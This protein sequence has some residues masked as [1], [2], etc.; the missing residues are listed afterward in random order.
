MTRIATDRSNTSK[1]DGYYYYYDYDLFPCCK[2]V[3]VLISILASYL[4]FS[5]LHHNSQLTKYKKLAQDLQ[6]LLGSSACCCVINKIDRM[7]KG[8]ACE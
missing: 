7:L 8:F 6:Y 2:S 4:S 1:F 3:M 5:Y